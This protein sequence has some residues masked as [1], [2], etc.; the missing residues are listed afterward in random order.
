MNTGLLPKQIVLS[1]KQLL[2]QSA[3]LALSLGPQPA[4]C[5]SSSFEC[6]PCYVAW[7]PHL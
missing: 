1:G 3:W 7:L 5:F 4:I 6:C 2:F